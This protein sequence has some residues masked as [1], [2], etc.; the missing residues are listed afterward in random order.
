MGHRPRLST[1]VRLTARTRRIWTWS[2]AAEGRLPKLSPKSTT[3]VSRGCIASRLSLKHSTVIPYVSDEEAE[4]ANKNVHLKL[5]FRLVSFKIMDEGMSLFYPGCG[6]SL[7]DLSIQ[8][9]M[10]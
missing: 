9:R 5:L 6:D 8:T 2:W 4:A 7:T 3:T 10:N 1:S